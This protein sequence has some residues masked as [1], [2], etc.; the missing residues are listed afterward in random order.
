M[1]LP[2]QL[3]A[4]H[5]TFI[6]ATGFGVIAILFALTIKDEDAA[7]SMVKTVDNPVSE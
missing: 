6:V 1:S 4:Y 7:A 2:T 5:M 3:F